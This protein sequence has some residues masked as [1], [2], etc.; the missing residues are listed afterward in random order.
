ML[1]IHDAI[2]PQSRGELHG[3]DACVHHR[4]VALVALAPDRQGLL[5]RHRPPEESWLRRPSALE[6]DGEHLVFLVGWAGRCVFM[7][8]FSLFCFCFVF[9]RTSL[10]FPS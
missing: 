8:K 6:P 7:M 5:H 4:S 9:P 2:H 1:G 3:A 10:C